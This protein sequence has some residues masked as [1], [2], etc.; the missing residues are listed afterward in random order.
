MGDSKAVE[1]WTAEPS[2]R[3]GGSGH[4]GG[5]SALEVGAGETAREAEPAGRDTTVASGEYDGGGAES[6]GTGGSRRQR[7]HSPVQRPPYAAADGPNAVWCADYKEWILSGD[8]TC[9]DPSTITDACS[10]YPRRAAKLWSD[11]GTKQPRRFLKRPFAPTAC[12]K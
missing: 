9:I 11:R 2:E 8:G 7:A 3:G 12:R 4:S 5:A 6:Q 10:R 1:T